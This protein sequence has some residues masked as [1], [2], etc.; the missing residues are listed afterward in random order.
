MLS[1]N[2]SG[3]TTSA[4]EHFLYSNSSQNDNSNCFMTDVDLDLMRWRIPPSNAVAAFER[5]VFCFLPHACGISEV[6]ESHLYIYSVEYAI[7]SF[8]SKNFEYVIQ[9]NCKT[10]PHITVLEEGEEGTRRRHF[11]P[12]FPCGDNEEWK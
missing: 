5:T 7:H 4:N 3:T 10:R 2:L 8:T 6:V 12:F 9:V 11:S 1:S